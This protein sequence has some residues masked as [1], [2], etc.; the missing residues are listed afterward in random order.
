VEQA[1][2]ETSAT[3]AMARALTKAMRF[4]IVRLLWGELYGFSGAEERPLGTGEGR[5]EGRRGAEALGQSAAREH[6]A[7]STEHGALL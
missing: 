4:F 3:A 2:N 6:G 7:R 5:A 1:I